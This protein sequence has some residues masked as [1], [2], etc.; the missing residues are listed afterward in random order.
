[1]A[2]WPMLLGVLAAAA[3]TAGDSTPEE[4]AG[5]SVGKGCENPSGVVAT[6]EHTGINLLGKDVENPSRAR[7]GLNKRIT[8]SMDDFSYVISVCSPPF[9]FVK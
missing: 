9:F 5:N 2:G 3:V 7:L 8:Y 6:E 1:M 4:H